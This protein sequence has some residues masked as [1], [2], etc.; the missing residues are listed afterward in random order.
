MTIKTSKKTAVDVNAIRRLIKKHKKNTFNGNYYFLQGV[1]IHTALF[2]NVIF[3]L[4]IH[5]VISGFI[6][7]MFLGIFLMEE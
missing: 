5:K 4:S 6:S 7:K 3:G 1:Q 2:F